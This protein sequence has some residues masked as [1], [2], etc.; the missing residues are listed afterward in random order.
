MNNRTTN[1]EQKGRVIALIGN[2]NCGKTTLFNGLTGG[3]HRIGNWPG[4]T[5]EKKEGS[6]KMKEPGTFLAT[7]FI[8]QGEI[9]D[10]GHTVRPNLQPLSGSGSAQITLV[11]LPGIYSLAAVTEDERVARDYLLSAQA[12]YI[13]N[14]LDAANLE[15][16]L[17]LTL[18]LRELGVPMVVVLT[19]MDIAH[20][21][22][23]RIYPDKLS[24]FLGVPV[25]TTQGTKAKEIQALAGSLS[26]LQG[27][28]NQPFKIPYDQDLE[29][30]INTLETNKALDISIKDLVS[31]DLTAARIYTKD[32]STWVSIQLIENPGLFDVLKGQTDSGRTVNRRIDLP[33]DHQDDLDILLAEAKYTYIESICSQV[34]KRGISNQSVSDKIDRFVMHRFWGIPF[35]FLV[36]YGVFWFTMYVGG[37]FIDF[38]DILAGALF[39]D[40]AQAI[41][42]GVGSPQWLVSL[43]AQGLGTGI[44]TIAT[45]IPIIFSMFFV[46]TLLEDSGYMARAAFVMDR[47]MQYLG[48]PGKAFIPMIVGFGCTVPGIM[49]T[50]TLESTKDR[51]TTIFMTPFMSC[52]ARLPVYALFVVALFPQHSGLVVFSIYLVGI[53]F[54]LLTGLLLKFTVFRGSSSH[55]VLELPPYH[56]PRFGYSIQNAG[57]RAWSFVVRA[58]AVIILAVGFLSILNSVS[59]QDG[60]VSFGEPDQPDSVLSQIGRIITPVFSPMGIESENWPAT[61]GL[62]T[63][64][65]AKEVVVGTLQSLYVQ[66][67]NIA[68]VGSESYIVLQETE[69]GFSLWANIQEAF[70][71]VVSNF[72]GWID[73]L[74]DPLGLGILQED[75]EELS[76]T[77]T[78]ISQYFTQASGYAYLLF[79]LIYTPCLAAIGAAIREMGKNWGIGLSFY[80][81]GLAWAV[82]V[83]FYQIAEGGMVI[84]IVIALGVLGVMVGSFALLSTNK[85]RPEGLTMESR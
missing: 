60:D 22:N 26:S 64:I 4:V 30:I 42:E 43:I 24:S 44:Q 84:W 18:Q 61:V 35:F 55:F 70:Q 56:R 65:F 57:K 38:F 50:R 47:F 49:G 76:D 40:G 34:V 9:L 74:R 81:L 63:G 5:V 12:D 37:G 67:V 80:L 11:D 53:L 36:M 21:R 31:T 45:F 7:P 32:F 28:P 19:M 77:A 8:G 71:S 20:N 48:L 10:Q 75:D 41:L 13:I 62:F 72:F 1:S 68:V 25:F 29:Q 83:I 82:S 52:G 3:N 16:N 79:I 39:V 54:A 69:P 59:I 66:E 23:I 73:G 51:F 27:I 85:Q 58:G 15:R 46:L 33:R 14:I 17:Y 78:L 2:P 6:L